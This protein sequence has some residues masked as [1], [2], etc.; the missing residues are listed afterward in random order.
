MKRLIS[1]GKTAAAMPINATIERRKSSEV[2]LMQST[3][4]TLGVLLRAAAVAI[5]LLSTITVVASPADAS[6][7]VTILNP[8]GAGDSEAQGARAGAFKPFAAGLGRCRLGLDGH[9][10]PPRVLGELA[11]PKMNLESGRCN[12]VFAHHKQRDAH[13]AGY[14]DARHAPGNRLQLLRWNCESKHWFLPTTAIPFGV[15]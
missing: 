12:F 7:N 11:R 3:Q 15:S 8:A 5:L 10:N 14:G 2:L 4:D 9:P 13:S 1:T 6:W